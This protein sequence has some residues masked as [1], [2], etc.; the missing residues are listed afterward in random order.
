[1]RVFRKL[2]KAVHIYRELARARRPG[3]PRYRVLVSPTPESWTDSV[4]R[5]GRYTPHE[6]TFAPVTEALVARHDVVLPLN[7]ADVLFLAD[8]PDL[9]RSHPLVHPA[10]AAVELLDDKVAFD[11]FLRDRG[12][13]ALLPDLSVH[14]APPVEPPCILKPVRG[15]FGQGCTVLPTR[16]DLDAHLARIGTAA[17]FTQQWLPGHHE[18]AV[19]MYLRR[20]KA[21]GSVGIEYEFPAD[22]AHPVKGHCTPLSTCLFHCPHLATWRDLLV[23]AGFEGICCVNYKYDA[24]GV[25][26]LLEIN[27]RI[28]GSLCPLL[29]SFLN[30]L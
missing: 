13:A 10:R 27:P 6:W 7:L 24:A 15:E 25:P 12:H 18:Y 30:R 17:H 11:R 29:F 20:G 19:H 16:E 9:T 21:L 22:V 14:P 23:L 5:F 2:N 8:R 4:R 28:G 26:K 1:M 3:A